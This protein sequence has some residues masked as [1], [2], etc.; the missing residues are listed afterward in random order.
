MTNLL[1]DN[2][3]IVEYLKNLTILCVDDE[4]EVRNS[5]ES[6]FSVLV[7]EFIEAVNGEDGYEKF[8]HNKVDIILTDYRMPKLNG[9]DMVAKIRKK[10]QA[11]PV[12]LTT[13]FDDKEIIIDAIN[14]RV[15]NFIKKPIESHKMLNALFDSAK[16]LIANQHLAEEKEKKLHTLEKKHTYNTYQEDLAFDKELNIL[17]NDF[18]YQMIYTD[19]ICLIDFLYQPLDIMSGDAYSARKIDENSNFYLMV[20]GM[21]KGLSASLTAMIMTTFVNQLI[22]K[23][24][25]F[26]DFNLETVVRESMLYIQ[27]ILLDEESLAIDFIVINNKTDELS[28]AKFA[29]PVLLMQNMHNEI[30]RIQSNNPPMCKYQKNIKISTYNVKNISKF[31]IYTDGLVENETTH[32]SKIY[33]SF[34]EEDFKNSFTKDD[35]KHS[36]MNKIEKQEDDITLIYIHRLK[37]TYNTLENQIFNTRLKEVDR[38]NEWYSNLWKTLINN[39]ALIYA[40]ELVFNELFM[41]AYEHGNIG[42][43]SHNKNLMLNDDIYYNTLL[44]VETQCD[45]KIKVDIFTANYNSSK[46]ILTVIT[47]EGIGFDTQ[48]LSKIFRNSRTFNGRGV[49]VSR[50]NSLGIYYNNK[51]NTVLFLN[52]I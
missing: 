3:E 46:Y 11:I 15:N 26:N 28:Y 38:A 45:K 8:L 23:M 51:G 47:D 40:N 43:N 49:F 22:D 2:A 36:F 18:Y 33:G 14:L 17:R 6:I 1:K 34:I 50:K 24:I 16:I 32:D 12:I 31:L 7:K 41:N 13:A 52:K 25:Q 48:I 21:G 35:F 5:Y 20:D 42:I 29:M 4:D 27:P 10:N 30:I 44:E 37:F 9:L 39:E 19:N